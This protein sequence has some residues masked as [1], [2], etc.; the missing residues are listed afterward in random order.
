MLVGYLLGNLPPSERGR[1]NLNPGMVAQV[2][3][4]KKKKISV[5]VSKSNR[6]SFLCC[7]TRVRRFA[8]QRA[9]PWHYCTIIKRKEEAFYI[10]LLLKIFSFFFFFFFFLIA[11]SS[12][13]E[14]FTAATKNFIPVLALNLPS[15]F[16]QRFFHHLKMHRILFRSTSRN[17]SAASSLCS[18][19]R[20]IPENKVK[21]KQNKTKEKKNQ[22]FC[23][24]T[25]TCEQ[26][27]SICLERKAT[28][29]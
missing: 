1:S 5:V 15:N 10:L 24:V 21:T 8:L 19:Q 9:R 3:R 6:H 16:L 12:E 27:L 14:A 28:T 20:L 23:F 17:V 2:W 4:R 22:F 13:I 29:D 18:D 25:S 26:T 11:S 7:K